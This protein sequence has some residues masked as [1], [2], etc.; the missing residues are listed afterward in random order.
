MKMSSASLRRGQTS[1]VALCAALF[2]TSP[3]VAADAAPAA[4]D[5]PGETIIVTGYATSVQK[6]NELKRDAAYSLDAVNSED[7]GKFPTR[8]AAEALQLIPGVAL[9]RQRGEGLLISVRGLGP[10]FQLVTLNGSS[11]AV[12]DLIENGGV[13]G[14]SFR[15]EVLPTVA[16]QQITVAKTPMAD[17]EEGALGGNIDVKTFKPFDIGTTATISTRLAYNSLRKKADPSVSGVVSW[18][19]TDK[20]F[21]VLAS[22]LYDKRSVRNDRFFNFG[23]NLNQFTT[24]ARGG[25]AAGLYTPTR[26]RPTIELEDRTRWSGSLSLQ[27]KPTSELETTIDGLITRLDVDYDEYGLDIYPDTTVAYP[28][29]AAEA[30]IYPTLAPLYT[31]ATAAR[32]A[33]GNPATYASPQFVAG[34][35]RIVGDTVVAGTINNVRWMASRE[36]SLNRH[37]LYAVKLRQRWT[38]GDWDIQGDVAYSYARSYH[39]PGLATTRNRTSFVAPLTFDFSGGIK[40][41]PTLT[42]TANYNDPN[43]YVGQAFDFTSKDSRD[44]DTSVRLDVARSFDGALTKIKFGGQ[45]HERNRDYIRRDWSINPVFGIPLTSATL[46]SNY[47]SPVPFDNFLSDFAGSSPR[48]WVSP[49]RTAFFNLIYTDAVAARAPDSASLRSSFEVSEK[50]YAAYVLEEFAFD[51]GAVAITGNAGVRYA[52]TKQVAS[53]TVDTAGVLLP[54]TYPKT[55]ED[56]LPSL[57]VRAQLT[58]KLVARIAASRTL[59]RPN[60]VDVAPRFTV[61]RDA[62]A[63]SGGNP[64]LNPY[65]ATQLDFALEWYFAPQGA[66][67]GAIFSKKLDS[68]ITATNIILQNVPGKVGDVLLSTQANGGKASLQGVE[69]SYNQ[70]FTFLPEPFDGLG[71]QASLTLIDVSSSYTAG[72]RTLTDRLVG[73]SKKSYNIVGYYEKGPFA[74]RLGYF[75]RDRYLDSNGSTVSTESYVAPF[76]SLDGSISYSFGQNFSLS[77]DAINL[78]N[79]H[80]FVYGSSEVQPREINDYGRTFTVS[81]RAKF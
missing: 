13:S 30:A 10:Q 32:V 46:G 17:M 40:T 72:N 2:A 52:Q 69:V 51:L 4:S 14:R 76:G 45:Y 53:G 47:Y 77:L 28:N 70:V 57:N 71:A 36:T 33:A 78:T 38:P 79:A 8:N 65:R 22:A 64:N 6:A 11:I 41:I 31:A 7:I 42:T 56:W 15:Y 80:K 27:W 34:T 61:S 63:A 16:I 39:P 1:I 74:T 24:A 18:V 67:S 73:L 29:F 50:I 66:L 9:V 43:I 3:A 44:S 26:T 12:N 81:A 60:L 62:N 49:S 5:E 75:W 58:P 21:G 55:Y 54:A 20:T 23:W 35:A 48:N 68:F 37:N 25:L 59:T 19:N